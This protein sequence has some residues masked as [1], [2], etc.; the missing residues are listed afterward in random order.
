MLN[1]PAVLIDT[2]KK[3]EDSNALILRLYEAHGTRGTAR[4]TSPLPVKRAVLCN[5]LEDEECELEWAEGGVNVDVTPFRIVTVKL[6]LE[7]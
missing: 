6:E 4:L 2:V 5:L 7:S 1:T 3:A